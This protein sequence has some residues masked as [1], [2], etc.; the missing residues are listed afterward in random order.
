[1]RLRRAE[2][3]KAPSK[4]PTK[5]AAQDKVPA[6]AAFWL[7]GVLNVALILLLFVAAGFFALSKKD[8]ANNLR[9]VESRSGMIARELDRG[10]KSLQ[11]RL[12]ALAD[13]LQLRELLRRGSLEELR[14]G[15]A[16]LRHTIPGAQRVRLFKLGLGANN[17]SHTEPLSYA[18]LDLISQAERQRGVTL[19]EVHRLGSPEEHLAIAA[20]IFGEGESVLGVVHVSLPST[21]LPS[22]ENRDGDQ[23]RILFQQRVG[24]QAVIVNSGE[25]EAAPPRLPV[26][27]VPI[28]GTR[29]R[30]VAWVGGGD[31]L[32]SG[33]LLIVVVGYLALVGLLALAMW[34]PLRSLRQALAMDYAGVVA[35]VE[36]AVN[37]NP[38]RRL[39]CRLAETKP[40]IEVLTRMLRDLEP[41]REVA[42]QMARQDA[43]A[44]MD[45]EPSVHAAPMRESRQLVGEE[46]D[47]IVSDTSARVQPT[48]PP[49]SVPAEI[50]RAYDIRGIIDLDLTPELMRFIG[51]A[52]GTE[53]ADSGDRTVVVGRDTRN[54]SVELCEALVTGLRESGCDVLDLG[55]APTPLV[56]FATQYQG[57]TSGVIVTASHNP[58]SYNGLKVVI[59]GISLAGDRIKELRERILSGSFSSGDGRYQEGDLVGDYVGRVEKDVAIART[60]KVVIDCGNAAASVVAPS[61]YRV[62]GCDLVELNCHPDAGFPQGRVPDPTRPEC[63]KAL[64]H[65]VVANGADLGLAF[66]GDGDRLGV[67]DSSGKVIWPDR[68]LMLLAADVLSRHPGT[69]VVFDVKSSK[70]LATEILR[71]G[72]RPVMWKSGHA[73]LKAKLQETGALLAGEWTGHI[74]FRERWFGFDDALYAGARLLEVLALDPRPSSEVFAGL[75]E[76][77][78]T[79]E[80]FLH[81]PEGESEQIM[82]AV[83]A[84]SGRLEGFDLFTEDGLRAETPQGWGLVRASNTQP[85]LVFRFEAEDDAELAKIQDVFRGIMERAAPELPL[86]F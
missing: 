74:I 26:H 68:V 76:A 27:E 38:M 46:T 9:Q 83:L 78:G 67:V 43:P 19:M 28:K 6:L 4:E 23:G 20:P 16:S 24:D 45:R 80:L 2:K 40:V 7:R 47:E 54:S 8:E 36:D 3:S 55:I 66:D 11:E 37:R 60:L 50:F 42:P 15:E 39:R 61:L 49:D 10:V 14:A 81:L 58:E 63:L 56:Y 22:V 1:M 44:V 86:P 75:P 25:G 33:V 73:P 62:L 70:N 53:T 72:G 77:I 57:E 71:H 85:A 31:A 21:L 84:Q 12:R 29:L 32:D 35:L 64:Q 30:V 59:N 41:A 5:A 17:D 18:G 82:Q 34:L 69:D 13:D 65:A 48:L 79:P 51:L 52:V